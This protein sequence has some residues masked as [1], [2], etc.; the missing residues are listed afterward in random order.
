MRLSDAL[1]AVCRPRVIGVI[2]LAVLVSVAGRLAFFAGD[3]HAVGSL[4]VRRVTPDQ[5]AQVMQAVDFYSTY[6][7][8]A[9][10]VRGRV[11]S[12]SRTDGGPVVMF[13]T[14]QSFGVSCAMAPGSPPVAPGAAITV[15]T[16]AASAQRQPAGLL[17][18]P[19]SSLRSARV[20][21]TDI[22]QTVAER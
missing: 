21:D 12:V 19:A 20:W 16:A 3:A 18:A 17:L 1:R 15:V 13:R 10:V 4:A 7:E 22:P 11:T 14:Q 2:L 6:R 9:L 5:L 8:D